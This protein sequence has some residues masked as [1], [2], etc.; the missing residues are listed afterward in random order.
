M[1]KTMNIQVEGVPAIMAFFKDVRYELS[2]RELGQIIRAGGVEVTR[3]AKRVIPFK[4]EVKQKLK[5]DLVTSRV[6]GGKGKPYVLVGPNFKET[7]GNQKV[8]VIAQ[9][10]TE[11]FKQNPR[12]SNGK[13][14]G[15][16]KNQLENTVMRGFQ[17]SGAKRDQA[18][19]KAM[20]RKLMKIRS[21]NKNVLI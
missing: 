13:S 15:V 18:M 7:I 14:R 4:G 6:K 1:A 19:N 20:Q 10:M 3:A 5:K 12:V 8:A 21:K 17:I 16:V 2:D 9:H 11:G